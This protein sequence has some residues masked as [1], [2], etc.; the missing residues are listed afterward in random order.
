MSGARGRPLRRI[1]LQPGWGKC[2]GLFNACKSAIGV[3]L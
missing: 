3:S 1:R 2:A